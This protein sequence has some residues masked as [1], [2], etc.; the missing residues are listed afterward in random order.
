V[1]WRAN[2]RV[3]GTWTFTNGEPTERR[4]QIPRSVL[5]D[6]QDL[7]LAIHVESPMSPMELGIAND[8]RHLGIV[9]SDLKLI[10]EGTR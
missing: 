9:F 4:L 8:P 6:S 10:G 7:R 1:T 2:D 5:E 3:V